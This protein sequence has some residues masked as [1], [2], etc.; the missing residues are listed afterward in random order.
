MDCHI[1]CLR[2]NLYGNAL[3]KAMNTCFKAVLLIITCKVGGI[4]DS[5]NWAKLDSNLQLIFAIAMKVDAM[6]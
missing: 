3:P 4:C 5:S 6:I 1:F 2:N